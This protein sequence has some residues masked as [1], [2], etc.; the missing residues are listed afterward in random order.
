MTGESDLVFDESDKFEIEAETLMKKDYRRVAVCTAHLL[1]L[2]NT[3]RKPRFVNVVRK[4]AADLHDKYCQGIKADE[5]GEAL[6]EQPSLG[7][8]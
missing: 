5:R 7:S 2:A 3:A 8:A 6:L 4:A 1:R